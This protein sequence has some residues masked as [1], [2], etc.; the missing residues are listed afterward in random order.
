MSYRAPR[1]WEHSTGIQFLSVD[2]SDTLPA[3]ENLAT[4]LDWDGQ[5]SLDFVDSGQG[6]MM[7]ECNP[8]PTDGVLLMTEELERGLL[9]PT[10][11]TL[12]VEPGREEQLDF[13][14]PGADLPPA[15]EGGAELDPRPRRRQGDRR[16]LARRAA[17]AL[18]VPRLRPPRA[19]EPE[20]AQGP[21]RGDVGRDHLGRPGDPGL[22]GRRRLSGEAD[23]RLMDLGIEGRVALVMGASKGSGAAS[24]VRWRRRSSSRSRRLG[25]SARRGVAGEIG[26][27][28]W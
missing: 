11:E 3:V 22:P 14:G 1:Q 5:M 7:I 4:E 27:V 6:L 17:A 24:P 18:L 23:R 28:M 12:Q 26:E 25:R 21:V 16:R 10:V 9:A 2:P 13:A 19:H 15:A 20:G 8:R